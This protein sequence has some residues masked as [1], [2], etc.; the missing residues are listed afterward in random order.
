MPTVIKKLDAGAY[1]L[2]DQVVAINRVM[3]EHFADK[4]LDYLSI[5]IE[6]LDYAVLKTLDYKKYRP[7]IICA[8]T[9]I[10]NTNR[11]NPDTTKLLVE[12]GYE[13][14]GMNLAN[15]FYVDRKLLPA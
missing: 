2:K 14:R 6:G 3:A 1:Q 15:T 12:N 10:T 7:K 13:V 5:D 8:E 11:H 4:P 9:L